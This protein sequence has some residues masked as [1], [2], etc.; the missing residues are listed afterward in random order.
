MPNTVAYL[1]H[2]VVMVPQLDEAIVAFERVGVPCKRIR[3]AG[4]GMRQAFFKLEESVFELVG[5]S[6]SEPRCWGLAFMCDDATA[7]VAI[8]RRNGLQATEPKPAI[9]GGRI[10]RIVAPLD[11]VADRL[12]GQ[13]LALARAP[14]CPA[15]ARE[16]AAPDQASLADCLALRLYDIKSYTMLLCGGVGMRGHTRTRRSI[17]RLGGLLSGCGLIAATAMIGV[18]G[19]PGIAGD[20]TAD[21]A[22]GQTDFVHNMVNFGGLN[23]LN[24]PGGVAIDASGHVYVADVGNNRVLGFANVAALANGAS[25]TIVIGQPDPFSYACT[26][27]PTGLCLTGKTCTASNRNVAGVAVD[28]SGNLYVADACDNRVLEFNSPFNSNGVV[29]GEAGQ[30]GVRPGRELYRQCLRQRSQRPL[31]AHRR[32]RRL[33][34]QRLCRGHGQQPRT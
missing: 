27:T 13:A 2:M 22:L 25:A 21:V 14:V 8:A 28:A 10:A 17:A 6:G 23:A 29:Q 9:Q 20:T 26:T 16:R 19:T 33:D 15:R 12:H 11:A 34:R 4:R 31:R 18:A 3:E 30:S 24:A 32:S 7:A 1:E 5:P